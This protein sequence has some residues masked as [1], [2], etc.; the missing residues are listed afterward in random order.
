MQAPLIPPFRGRKS[1]ARVFYITVLRFGALIPARSPETERRSPLT[2]A[3]PANS[4]NACSSPRS[5]ST[6][7]SFVGS[8]SSSTLID[9]RHRHRPYV[10]ALGSPPIYSVIATSGCRYAN[11]L[12]EPNP[13]PGRIYRAGR[14]GPLA[15][16]AA[17]LA[18][19]L[20]I[21]SRRQRR[22]IAARTQGVST[23]RSCR[24]AC[25]ERYANRSAARSTDTRAVQPA[26]SS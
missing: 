9:V 10:S 8:S 24:A 19:R 26:D 18:S 14:G 2:T 6:S 5:V 23:D 1:R 15:A 17:R 25:N 4:T 11:H 12:R 3:H 13:A 21:T 7:R 16:L 22:I 20:S